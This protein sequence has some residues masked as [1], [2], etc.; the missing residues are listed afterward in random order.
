MA[1]Q[2]L[3][4]SGDV[5]RL[6]VLDPELCGRYEEQRAARGTAG[7]LATPDVATWKDT[8]RRIREIIPGFHQPPR[9][10]DLIGR[11]HDRTVILVNL[12]SYRSDCLI[13][14]DGT[15]TVIP[16]SEVSPDSAMDEALAF[17]SGFLMPEAAQA[18]PVELG[19]R[20]VEESLGRIWDTIAMPALAGAGLLHTGEDGRTEREEPPRIWWIPCGQAAQLP[21]HAAGRRDPRSGRWDGTSVVDMVVSSYALTL[22]SLVRDTGTQ[23]HS[24]RKVLAI[25]PDSEGMPAV[26][27]ELESLSQYCISEPLSGGGL[28]PRDVLNALRGA[29]VVHIVCHGEWNFADPYLSGFILGSRPEQLLRVR[30]LAALDLPGAELAYL[31]ACSTGLTLT[32]VPQLLDEGVTLSTAM[33]L[34]GF[35]NVI[36]TW[37]PVNDSVAVRAAREVYAAMRGPDQELDTGRSAFALRR[38]VLSLRARYPDHPSAWAAYLHIGG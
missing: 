22:R 20:E 8:L 15:V 17:Y 35:Q 1:E 37:H 29:P 18:I 2:L 10:A 28:M 30:E 3:D 26:T 13:V 25:A 11:L 27:R 33:H 9:I 4:V 19:E 6:R 12:S 5:E 24:E 36:G 32:K 31:S 23:R 38:A 7:G 16:L 34:A 21:L 14:Q